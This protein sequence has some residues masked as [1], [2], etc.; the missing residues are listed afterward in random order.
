M[1]CLLSNSCSLS[2]SNEGNHILTLQSM[3]HKFISYKVIISNRSDGSIFLCAKVWS[4]KTF[5][6]YIM[7]EMEGCRD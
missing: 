1:K 3:M 7:E 6:I 4:L 5:M 2:N